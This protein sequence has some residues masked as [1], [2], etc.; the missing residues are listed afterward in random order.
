MRR[1]VRALVFVLLCAGL[2]SADEIANGQ[3]TDF[4]NGYMRPLCDK[5]AAMNATLATVVSTYNARDLGTIINDAGASNLIT[6]GSV[7]DGRTRITGGD[8][9]NT[10]TLIQDLQTFLTSGRKDV[11]A[12]CQVNGAPR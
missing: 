6:D 5:L 4:T 10:V 1:F 11:I 8:V 3:L 12:K 9:F 2:A 7:T